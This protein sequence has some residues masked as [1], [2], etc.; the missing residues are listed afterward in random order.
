MLSKKEKAEYRSE[1]VLL[2][3]GDACDGMNLHPTCVKR[4]LDV[5]P[6][7]AD[8]GVYRGQRHLAGVIP[9]R[10]FRVGLRHRKLAHNLKNKIPV[11][12]AHVPRV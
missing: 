1:R 3:H 8:V 12:V 6:G 10:W 7:D 9:A 2:N 5:G 4:V 11:F